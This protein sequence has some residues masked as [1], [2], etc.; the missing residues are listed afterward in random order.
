MKKE[1]I[2]FKIMKIIPNKVLYWL[3]I[4]IMAR[5]T[6]KGYPS[7]TPDEITFTEISSF[8]EKPKG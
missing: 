7:K 1:I 8:L 2:Y 4:E 5:V 3:Y 6:T